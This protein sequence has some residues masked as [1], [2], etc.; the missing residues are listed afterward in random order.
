MQ[1]RA[2]ALVASS[3]VENAIKHRV[4]APHAKSPPRPS[5]KVEDDLWLPRATAEA[6]SHKES[7]PS[8]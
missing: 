6:S 3:A 2:A 8:P 1:I 5:L 4:L 7:W